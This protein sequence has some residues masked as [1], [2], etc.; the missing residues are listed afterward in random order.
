MTFYT[1]KSCELLMDYY[2]KNGGEVIELEEGCLG[3][4]LVLCTCEGLKSTIIREVYLNE[5][6]SG[7]TMR[8]Y[9][10]LPAKY[11]KMREEVYNR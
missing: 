10:K 5:W 4:G 11:E 6:A 7:H 9:N 3:L 2:T 1:L 8:K